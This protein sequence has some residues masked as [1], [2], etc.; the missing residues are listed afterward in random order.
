[1][2]ED[3]AH[4]FRDEFNWVQRQA[5]GLYP[6]VSRQPC[7]L[8]KRIHGSLCDHPFCRRSRDDAHTLISGLLSSQVLQNPV[9]DI[10]LKA[11]IRAEI[12][13]ISRFVLQ[14]SNEERLTGNLVS[15][16]DAAVFLAKPVFK[17]V[18]R[19]RYGEEREIDF[20]YYDL[21]RGGKVEKQTG[22][23]LAFIVVVD[24]PDFPFVVRGVVLQAKKCDPSATINVR[25]LHTIQKMSQDAA[26][27]LFYDMSFSSL[28]SPMVVAISRFQ[29]KV[30]EAEKYTKNSFSVQMENILDLGVPLSL[31]LLEDVI[32]KGMGTTY[33]SFE[34]AFGC[35]LN[36]AIQQDF[37]DGFNGRVA[38]ASVG[39]RISLIPGP[40]GGVHVEV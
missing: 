2:K 18:A 6:W 25:Q 15:E 29:S 21:S 8:I 28:S 10:F 5:K 27:Y 20:Y 39:R 9:L 16:L 3:I 12:R 38:I 24:L 13:F 14:R 31:F 22:A 33:S 1:M 32:H 37:P 19:E 4:V 17:S 30:E 26:A 7:R 40:E 36:L 23:D 35:F 11:L 34:S